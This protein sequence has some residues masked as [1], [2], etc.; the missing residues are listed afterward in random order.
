MVCRE[1]Y[2]HLAP[3]EPEH[4]L[5][6]AFRHCALRLGLARL[7]KDSHAENTKAE[8]RKRKLHPQEGAPVH[9]PGEDYE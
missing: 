3:L 1:V 4:R 7:S 5:V 8:Q 9:P 6:A 2:K